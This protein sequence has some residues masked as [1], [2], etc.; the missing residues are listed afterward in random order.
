[1]KLGTI[2]ID[3]S[4]NGFVFFGGDEFVR[5]DSLEEEY[6]KDLL[7]KRREH[8]IIHIPLELFMSMVDGISTDKQKELMLWLL[9]DKMYDAKTNR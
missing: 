6:L 7:T 4:G 2:V 3:H 9:K 1:M 8:A 5:I